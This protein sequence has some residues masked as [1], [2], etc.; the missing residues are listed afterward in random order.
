M[1]LVFR[2]PVIRYTAVNPADQFAS[3]TGPGDGGFELGYT[4]PSYNGQPALSRRCPYGTD[5][6]SN[7]VWHKVDVS[8]NHEGRFDARVVAVPNHLFS[9]YVDLPPRPTEGFVVDR[10]LWRGW[11]SKKY[12]INTVM[13]A[14]RRFRERYP[15][16]CAAEVPVGVRMV[17]GVVYFLCRPSV[18]AFMSHIENHEYQ[19][20]ADHRWLAEKIFGPVDS[21]AQEAQRKRLVFESGDAVALVKWVRLPSAYAVSDNRVYQYWQ[22]AI[23]QSGDLYHLTAV[24]ASPV[25]RLIRVQ[26]SSNDPLTM[27]F[28]FE[29]S[30]PG[31]IGDVGLYSPPHRVFALVPVGKSLSGNEPKLSYSNDRQEDRTVHRPDVFNAAANSTI[32]LGDG[33]D[34]DVGSFFADMV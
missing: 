25:L 24:G 18:A 21:W 4:E 30:P 28:V 33:D 7:V 23:G 3:G 10:S 26:P 16:D 17:H 19:H 27:N 9:W 8:R 20:V 2:E 14:Y 22:K 31:R 15:R 34:F 1:A 5:V 6:P 12:P 13:V 32:P 11:V 29:I